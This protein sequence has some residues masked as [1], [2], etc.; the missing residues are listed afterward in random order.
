MDVIGST[1]AVGVHHHH[2]GF[3]YDAH[4]HPCVHHRSG[5]ETQPD[6]IQMQGRGT[7]VATSGWS[8]L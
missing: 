8:A 6:H 3:N 4:T 1:T 5:D 2:E 7:P